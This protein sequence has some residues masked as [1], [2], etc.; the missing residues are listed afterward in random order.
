MTDSQDSPL[1]SVIMN[2]H[3]SEKFLAEALESVIAQT[4]TNWEVILW[5][6]ASTDGS[7]SIAAACGDD[8]IRYF[9]IPDKVSLYESRMNAFLQTRGELVAFL[10]CDDIWDSRKLELQ[11]PIF[12][13]PRCVVSSTDYFVL[14]ES[15][16]PDWG[17]RRCE[18]IT[19]SYSEPVNSIFEL[20]TNYRIGMSTV[21]A[22]H[23]VARKIWPC[24]PPAYSM[25]EDL[26]MTARLLNGGWLFSIAEPL[27]SYRLH[28]SN[29]SLNSELHEPEWQDWLDG[30]QNLGISYD[31]AETARCAIEGRR[32]RGKCNEALMAGHRWKC[33]SL[34]SQMTI[35]VDTLKYGAAAMV[36][37]RVFRAVV[38]RKRPGDLQ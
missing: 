16:Q 24:P 1:V 20:I 18:R 32:I 13:D 22:R 25:I 7:E 17:W 5:D 38:N 37:T 11:V 35:S 6:N 19:G 15:V 36:P 30:L 31:E 29:Y 2:A 34:L 27:T 12:V 8:R 9:A 23:D 3:N 28:G 10:D 4:Y 33:L 26:D 14:R 21:M